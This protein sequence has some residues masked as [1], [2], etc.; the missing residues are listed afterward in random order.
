MDPRSAYVSRLLFADEIGVG[1]LIKCNYGD[2]LTSGK[3]YV[4]D[5]SRY[6]KRSS[7][8]YTKTWNIL[9]SIQTLTGVAWLS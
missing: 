1:Y 8:N 2:L 4:L 9:I 6:F 5:Y 3:K 7:C